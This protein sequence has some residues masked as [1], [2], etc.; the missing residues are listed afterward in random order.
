MIN[1]SN[2]EIRKKIRDLEDKI[3][4]CKSYIVSDFCV[5]CTDMY[6]KIHQYEAEIKIL[7]EMYAK[8]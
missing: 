8:S 5:R 3:H 4:D 6:E 1:P 7:K 2:E